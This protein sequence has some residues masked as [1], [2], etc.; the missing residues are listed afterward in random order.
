V[1]TQLILD[2]QQE[3]EK[4]SS[5]DALSL[6][7]FQAQVE[8]RLRHAQSECQDRKLIEAGRA[9][10]VLALKGGHR[11][12]AVGAIPMVYLASITNNW[13]ETVGSGGF[14]TVYKGQ[15]AECG[16]VVGIKTIPR[17]RERKTTSRK[18]LR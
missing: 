10:V 4:G 12:I 16:V 13:T 7:A 9:S 3:T 17:T 18:K 8:E 2:I 6:L 14:G 15:D 5:S 1:A 11:D